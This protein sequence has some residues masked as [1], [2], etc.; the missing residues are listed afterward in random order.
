MPPRDTTPYHMFRKLFS[1]ATFASHIVCQT[2]TILK[3]L[4]FTVDK[5]R[6]N[7]KNITYLAFRKLHEGYHHKLYIFRKIFLWATF[8][9]Q[10]CFYLQQ[11][12]SYKLQ[13]DDA[14]KMQH[15][16]S[17]GGHQKGRKHFRDATLPLCKPTLIGHTIAETFVPVQNRQSYSR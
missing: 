7:T 1:R 15:I 6:K 5:T 16:W 14:R 8:D 3:L 11:L 12:K 17:Y 10:I 2:C 13:I 4:S 9:S